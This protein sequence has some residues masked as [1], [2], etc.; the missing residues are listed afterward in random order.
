MKK[1]ARGN[2]GGLAL[3]AHKVHTLKGPGFDRIA[4]MRYP[5]REAFIGYAMGQGKGDGEARQGPKQDEEVMAAGFKLREAGLA[6]QGLVCMIPENA[7]VPSAPAATASR[8]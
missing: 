5:N 2:G 6:K 1:S 4:I 8:L 7:Y 3:I